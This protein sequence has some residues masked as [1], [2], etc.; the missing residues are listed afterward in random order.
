[1]GTTTVNSPWNATG[2]EPQRGVS[3]GAYSNPSNPR[4]RA[5][6][7]HIAHIIGAGGHKPVSAKR[8]SAVPVAGGESAANLEQALD[9]GM[10]GDRR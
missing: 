6:G 4:Q 5:D 1:M 8:D 9:R 7:G 3:P 2:N 10:R